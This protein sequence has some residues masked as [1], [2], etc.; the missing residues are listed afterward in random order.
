M[1][2]RACAREYQRRRRANGSH[3]QTAQQAA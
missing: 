2:C 3:D 1:A